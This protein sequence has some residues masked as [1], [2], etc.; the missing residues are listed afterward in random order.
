MDIKFDKPVNYTD[1]ATASIIALCLL[2]LDPLAE[3]LCKCVEPPAW[4]VMVD[5][6]LDDLDAF[7]GCLASASVSLEGQ[8][9]LETLILR[10]R[11]LSVWRA[12]T[13]LHC[14]LC[15]ALVLWPQGGWF[16]RDDRNG[17]C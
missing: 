12:W 8:A 1:A 9:P 16:G 4:L 11:F 13:R 14:R 10:R 7:P 15:R 6:M 3:V 17:R 2:E 5:P